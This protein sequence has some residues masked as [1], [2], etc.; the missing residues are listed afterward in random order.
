M[1]QR[2]FEKNIDL[3]VFDDVWKKPKHRINDASNDVNRPPLPP[4]HN[5]GQILNSDPASS[6]FPLERNIWSFEVWAHKPGFHAFCREIKSVA[7]YA[8]WTQIFICVKKWHYATLRR[9]C[10]MSEDGKAREGSGWTCSSLSLSL[11]LWH[12]F[13]KLLIRESVSFGSMPPHMYN[14]LKCLLTLNLPA[15]LNCGHRQQASH[16]PPHHKQ[17]LLRLSPT[18]FPLG[19]IYPARPHW[20]GSPPGLSPPLGNWI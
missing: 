20:D 11:S 13:N 4:D 9:Q 10:W 16:H 1:F 19:T 15:L 2:C 17:E 8:F 7:T 18:Q 3:N 5:L 14:S 6:Y 12:F